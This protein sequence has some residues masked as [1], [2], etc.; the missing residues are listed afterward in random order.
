MTSLE[1]GFPPAPRILLPRLR[2]TKKHKPA[3]CGSAKPLLSSCVLSLFTQTRSQNLKG[4]QPPA[5]VAGRGGGETLRQGNKW[6]QSAGELVERRGLRVAPG[7]AVCICPRRGRA[8]TPR[9]ALHVDRSGRGWRAVLI[10]GLVPRF[11]AVPD[12]DG[13]FLISGAACDTQQT[14]Q[15]TETPQLVDDS[16]Q[17]AYRKGRKTTCRRQNALSPPGAPPFILN[18]CYVS[19]FMYVSV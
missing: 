16:L 9:R 17:S 6:F 5:R 13:H 2:S 4:S 11:H 18:F 3:H 19:L 10:P 8:P 7:P 14:F 1:W 12:R 15:F